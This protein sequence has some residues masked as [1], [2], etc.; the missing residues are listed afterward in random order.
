[1][2]YWIG[3]AID[4]LMWS[5]NPDVK[6]ISLTIS[7]TE[8]RISVGGLPLIVKAA[9][10]QM[11]VTCTEY[12]APCDGNLVKLWLPFILV[13]AET[14]APVGAVTL[15]AFDSKG[16][17]PG[18]HVRLVAT[19]LDDALRHTFELLKTDETVGVALRSIHEI[20]EMGY[21]VGFYEEYAEKW[22]GVY[23][24]GW[25][26]RKFDVSSNIFLANYFKYG[27]STTVKVTTHDSYFVEVELTT[28]SSEGTA[29]KNIG[30]AARE[31]LRPKTD[32][33][34]PP[35]RYLAIVPKRRGARDLFPRLVPLLRKV[36][37]V[38][39]EEGESETVTARPRTA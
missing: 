16:V 35:T 8:G 20:A 38:L 12:S 7:T 30:R 18:R 24:G 11:E 39:S 14:E 6:Y 13:D 2:D 1:M 5:R 4:E 25:S 37:E 31:L 21:A 23:A 3:R 27:N 9:D 32:I 33:E 34:D 10:G 15:D 22:H 17:S 26:D 36:R 28:A 29:I 19:V